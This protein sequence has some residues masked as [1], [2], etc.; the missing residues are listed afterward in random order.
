MSK[1]I[2]IALISSLL[3]V[4]LFG[5]AILGVY[6]YQEGKYEGGDYLSIDEF[7]LYVYGDLSDAYKDDKEVIRIYELCLNSE[8]KSVCVYENID[9][10]WSTSFEPLRKDYFFSPTEMTEHDGYGVCRDIAIFRVAVLKK[11]NI[12]TQFVFIPGHV[13]IKAFEGGKVYELDNGYMRVK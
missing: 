5:I 4:I 10:T 6:M 13:Y 1:K 7:K 9:F 11:L 12:P 3:T 8:I 2:K